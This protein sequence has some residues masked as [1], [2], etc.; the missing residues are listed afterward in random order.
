MIT[1][2]EIIQSITSVSTY[3]KTL[4]FLG[5][6]WLISKLFSNLIDIPIQLVSLCIFILI[7]IIGTY[8]ATSPLF[9]DYRDVIVKLSNNARNNA[10]K[11]QYEQANNNA[12]L[13]DFKMLEAIYE[14]LQAKYN[15][16]QATEKQSKQ[17]ISELQ[18]ENSELK[19]SE[20]NE[21]ATCKQE[22]SKEKD[23][24]TQM[25]AENVTRQNLINKLQQ[26]EKFMFLVQLDL[27]PS[28]VAGAVTNIVNAKSYANPEQ[29]QN[30]IE[31]LNKIKA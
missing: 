22:L 9:I 11:L 14:N 18:Q 28:K 19:A 16:L 25:Q 24:M 8:L 27:T 15:N 10:A 31:L 13:A 26:T 17:I 29:K 4:F 7:T 1:T 2:K 6:I 5:F 30:M 12:I 23:Y 21:L 3:F 20:T